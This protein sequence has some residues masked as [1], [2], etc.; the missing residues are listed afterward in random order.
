MTFITSFEGGLMPERQT[1]T[2]VT[3]GAFGLGAIEPAPRVERGEITEK[4]VDDF[5]EKLQGD[6]LYDGIDN[7]LPKCCVDGRHRADGTCQIGANAAGGVFSLLAADMLTTQ[8][9]RLGAENT[10]DYAENMFDYLNRTHP[11]EFGDHDADGVKSD[12]DSGCGAVDKMSD[13]IGLIAH[14][15][16]DLRAVASAVG[17]TID[18]DDF[19]TIVVR[20][21]Q[22]V[23]AQNIAC[24]TGRDAMGVLKK[25]AGDE[26]VETLTGTHNEVVVV[27]NEREGTT[28]NRAK[29]RA[30][31]GDSF[32]AFNYDRWAMRKAVHSIGH[33][34]EQDEARLKLAAADLYN[35][36]VTCTLAGSS[37][38][39]LRRGEMALQPLN[40]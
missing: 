9:F 27:V 39:G 8:T 17:I 1:K 21:R 31:Y 35:I 13:A 20:A 19:D 37:L 3:L 14:S 16:D 22:I 40:M 34:I 26:S 25:V 18:D 10:A 32:Q 23:D 6:E 4:E 30:G 24:A 15:S 38:R 33:N 36:A 2:R 5:V 7:V 28:L 12:T 11:G 29:V